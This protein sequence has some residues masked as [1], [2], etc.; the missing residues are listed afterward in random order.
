MSP[1]FAKQEE[2]QCG[3]PNKKKLF[4]NNGME[5]VTFFLSCGSSAQLFFVFGPSWTKGLEPRMLVVA[6]TLG[7]FGSKSLTLVELGCEM[8]LVL[9]PRMLVVA[10][11]PIVRALASATLGWR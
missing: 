2:Y 9:E 5:A 6:P 8:E 11:A 3:I 10:R 4:S 1:F 7:G